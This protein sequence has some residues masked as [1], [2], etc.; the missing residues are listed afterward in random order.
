MNIRHTEMSDFPA[1]LQIYRRARAFMAA[2]GNPK[3]WG[4]HWPPEDLLREDIEAGR[5]YVCE[6]NGEVEV[7]ISQI[8]GQTLTKR[9]KYKLEDGI[10]G[11]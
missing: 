9:M 6:E 3:Q 8:S 2:S 1:L 10:Y 7:Y 5:S 11:R 4:D